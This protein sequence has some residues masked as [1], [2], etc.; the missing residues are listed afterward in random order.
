MA[1]GIVNGD[2]AAGVHLYLSGLSG[3]ASRSGTPQS[4]LAVSVAD[5]K[6]TY[7]SVGAPARR[8]FT[9]HALTA[10]VAV[11]GTDGTWQVLGTPTLQAAL[12]FQ[13]YAEPLASLLKSAGS[14]Y[15]RD[16]LQ[17]IEVDEMDGLKEVRLGAT[18]FKIG[19]A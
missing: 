7:V 6:T 13:S 5:L 19:P 11:L 2:G 9:S 18:F 10:I 16:P 3:K 17:M 14:D 12:T 15:R 1:G 8:Y 4:P